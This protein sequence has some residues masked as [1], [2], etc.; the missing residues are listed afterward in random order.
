MDEIQY[1][2]LLGMMSENN[3]KQDA[4]LAI[5]KAKENQQVNQSVSKEEI[6][7]IVHDKVSDM[8]TSL[9]LK[10]KQQIENQTNAIN[11]KL[12]ALPVCGNESFPQTKKITFFGFEFLRSSV[13]ILILSIVVFWSLVVNIKQMD[14]NEALKAHCNQL[15][16]YVIHLQKTEKVEKPKG[17]KAK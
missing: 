4:I 17:N 6:E 2:G 1:E 8:A 7:K 9:E 12:V 13:V 16:E 5:C 3:K 10:I 11:K 14:N 15:T